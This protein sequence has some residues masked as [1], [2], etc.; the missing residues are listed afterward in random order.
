MNRIVINVVE[1]VM[2]V[3]MLCFLVVLFI[4][5]CRS[6]NVIVVKF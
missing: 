1:L 2:I 4:E 5:L 6:R 3:I